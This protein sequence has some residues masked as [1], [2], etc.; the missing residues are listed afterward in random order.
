MAVAPL[1]DVATFERTAAIDRFVAETREALF[2]RRVDSLLM[3]RPDRTMSINRT[4]VDI[5]EALYADPPRA[6]RSVLRDLAPR[7]RVDAD[8]LLQDVEAL[9][10][11]VAAVLREDW[12]PRQ[13]LTHGGF[14]RSMIGYPTIA[15]IALTY[16]CQAKCTFCYASSPYRG[17][18]RP[19]MTT[20]EVK[21]VMRR[22]AHEAHVPSLSFTGGEATLRDDLAELITY[23]RSLGLRINLI[24][25]GLRLADA[26]LAARLVDAGLSSAQ[27]SLEAAD[28]DLHDQIVGVPGGHGKL[29]AGVRNLRRLGIHVHTNSTLCA[30]NLDHAEEIVAFVYDELGGEQL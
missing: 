14:D 9:I 23:G 27:I 29:V 15:E 6:T 16:G 17:D 7:L 25:N 19:P 12:S 13:G 24:S 21:A 22:V 8:R 2:V 5:L 4:A 28:P 18:E 10:G 20:D 30:A 3:I 11:A 26:D 1:L